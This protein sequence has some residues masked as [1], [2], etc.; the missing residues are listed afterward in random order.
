LDA[1][2]KGFAVRRKDAVVTL[3]GKLPAEDARKLLPVVDG[4]GA[5]SACREQS[6]PGHAMGR[7]WR[8]AGCDHG[9]V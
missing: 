8:L 7:R 1:L 9:W 4:P 5:V 2:L 3:S 6:R